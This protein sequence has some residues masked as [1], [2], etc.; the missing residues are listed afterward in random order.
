MSVCLERL[1]R[2]SIALFAL[3]TAAPLPVQAQG[4]FAD[5]ADNAISNVDAI[6][7]GFRN[8]L[9]RDLE[10]AGVRPGPLPV[11]SETELKAVQELRPWW[12]STVTKSLA[13]DG[14]AVPVSLAFMY[15]SAIINAAQLR[16]FGDLPAIRDTAEDEV[17]GRYVPRGFVEGRVE[18]RA[19]PTDN[20]ATTRGSDRLKRRERAVEFGLRQRV[21]TGGEVTLGQR[22]SNT[23]TNSTD[24]DPANQTRART[25]VTLVQP[26]LRE[27]GTDYVRSIH[28][29]ARVDARVAQSEFRRQAENHLL[30]VARAYWTL[31]LSRATFLQ[32]ER[33]VDEVVPLVDQLEGRQGLDTDDLLLSRARAALATRTADLQRARAAIRNAEAR[34]RGLVNDPRFS[35]QDIAELMPAD[36]P[37]DRYEPITLATVLERAIAFRP[38]VQQ[39]YLQHRA[40]V[41][42]EGQAQIEALPR[43]DMVLEG[44]L[45]GRGVGDDEF[46]DSLD[47]TGDGASRPSGLVGLRFE[48]PLQQDDLAVR[49]TRRRLETRQVESQG[50]ATLATIVTESE[51]TLNEYNVA[52]REV[53]ARSLALDAAKT[54]L[55]IETE[56]W[57]QGIGTALSDPDG[58]LARLLSAQE[59]LTEA[60]GRLA[61]AQVD[62]TLAFLAL[63]RVQGTFSSLENLDFRRIEDAAR[64]PSYVVR[65]IPGAGGSPS[66]PQP[67]LGGTP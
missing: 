31:H 11:P 7:A 52:F 8:E 65:R 40:A 5:R 27:S 24:F 53:A 32:L 36:A 63:S 15:D 46:R 13:E 33:L 6:T 64:G 34:L 39:I 55:D 41:L 26:L 66:T 58:T 44:S 14:R 2:C 48:V 67:P 59:R 29:V 43:L 47:D 20:L 19:D 16:V 38:E 57:R 3:L 1:R 61:T 60:E 10:R 54:Q 35:Q 62:F 4:W 28:E 18:D 37:L 30:E 42:R 9:R 12:Q 17:A 22:F 50:R 21:I 56:L 51:V 23:W 45:G 25:F 49:R